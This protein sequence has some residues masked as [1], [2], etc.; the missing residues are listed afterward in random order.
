MSVVGASNTRK[1]LMLEENVT[2]IGYCNSSKYNACLI[3]TSTTSVLPLLFIIFSRYFYI[4]H[5]QKQMATL[6]NY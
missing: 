1:V 3:I 2:V 5:A 6:F 4:A